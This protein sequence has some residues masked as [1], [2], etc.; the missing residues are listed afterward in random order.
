MQQQ[1]GN[2]GNGE[3]AMI[4]A[5]GLSHRELAI[6]LRNALGAGSE[7]VNIRNVCGQRYIGTGMQESAR[8]DIYGVPGNDLGC[9]MQGP[10]IHVHGNA[11]DGCGNTLDGGELIVHGHAGDI[12]GYS[13]RGGKMFIRDDVGYRAAI[14]MKACPGKIPAIVI[15][16]GAQPF[17]GEYMSGGVVVVLGLNGSRE[18]R[19]CT[20][21]FVGTGMHGGTIYIRGRVENWQLGAEVAADDARDL[22][23]EGIASLVREFCVHFDYDSEAILKDPFIRISPRH[24]RPYGKLYAY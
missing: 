24:L 13:M 18:A 5:F 9:F 11:Q 2:R 19:P 22:E 20:A 7:R 6:R 15:G 1:V 23:G 12:A 17:L 4:D 14:H 8:I 10:R 16:G 21:G 3:E